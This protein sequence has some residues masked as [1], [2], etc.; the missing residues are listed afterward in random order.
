M[1]IF[2]VLAALFGALAAAFTLLDR[3]VTRR[4][5]KR[6]RRQLRV[7]RRFLKTLP[8]KTLGLGEAKAAVVA[9]HAYFGRPFG[10]RMF[11][12][13]TLLSLLIGLPLVVIGRSEAPYLTGNNL[14]TCFSPMRILMLVVSVS[15]TQIILQSS[16]QAIGE[17]R[18]GTVLFVIVLLANVAATHLVALYAPF[19]DVFVSYVF[20]GLAYPED[21]R[22]EAGGTGLEVA[23]RNAWN[24]TF[25]D[26]GRNSI[27]GDVSVSGMLTE[28]ISTL[29]SLYYGSV[30]AWTFGYVTG[31]I[32]AGLRLSFA[33]AFVNSWCAIILG[34]SLPRRVL[35]AITT[36]KLSVAAAL[37]AFFAALATLAGAV[38]G[39]IIA[40]V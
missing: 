7:W 11:L 6:L 22:V 25:G 10:W 33:L 34:I 5:D 32:I 3:L 14:I 27:L 9:I 15:I 38:K 29:R 36:S 18:F 16:I 19:F 8:I 28:E 21:L 37:S 40:L 39:L 4:E 13:C 17:A 24:W 35:F 31:V 30:T 12:S 23:I 20:R 2:I 26:P 1:S